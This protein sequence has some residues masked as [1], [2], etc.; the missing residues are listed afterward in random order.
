MAELSGDFLVLTLPKPP[1]KRTVLH[2]FPEIHRQSR[3][4]SVEENFRFHYLQGTEQDL[5]HFP[6]Y[7][8]GFGEQLVYSPR[9]S[10]SSPIPS[11][12]TDPNTQPSV[13][14]VTPCALAWA[15]FPLVGLSHPCSV[16]TCSYALFC[17]LEHDS[18]SSCPSVFSV[19]ILSLFRLL[20]MLLPLPLPC[21]LTWV[22]GE[23][24]P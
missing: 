14:S 11:Q 22:P 21:R 17:G 18:P 4:W 6:S 9:I 8:S 23:R 5:R 2:S 12:E 20:C 19:V 3:F 15:V 1:F 16:G 24:R 7:C 10:I 13:E